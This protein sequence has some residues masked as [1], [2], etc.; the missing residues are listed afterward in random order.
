MTWN[1]SE[2]DFDPRYAPVVLTSI[3]FLFLLPK[4]EM[5]FDILMA[6]GHKTIFLFDGEEILYS[7]LFS[8]TF[9]VLLNDEEKNEKGLSV[10]ELGDL[11]RI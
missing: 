9:F 11:G 2:V 7:P 1:H 10:R 3:S 8:R 4:V 5:N 6:W